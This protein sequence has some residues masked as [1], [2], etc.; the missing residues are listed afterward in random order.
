[1]LALGIQ[2]SAINVL[3]CLLPGHFFNFFYYGANF[4]YSKPTYSKINEK[5][6]CRCLENSNH[7]NLDSFQENVCEFKTSQRLSRPNQQ[8]H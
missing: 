8:V 6:I 1:M 5:A 4:S 3:V 7:E 2:A